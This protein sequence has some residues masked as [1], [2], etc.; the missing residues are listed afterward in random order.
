MKICL[1]GKNLTNFVLAKNLANKN[2]NVDI[3]CDKKKKIENSQRTLGIS[4]DNFDFLLNVNK[5]MKISA[6]PIKNIK[7]YNDKSHSKEF[8]EFNNK[9]KKN[10]FL[11]KYIDILNSFEKFC[12]KNKNIK[13]LNVNY[14]SEEK[15]YYLKK[16]YKL[17]IN[18]DK[19][20]NYNKK[21][22]NKKIEKNYN[23][24][25]YT[26]ILI[27]ERKVNYEAIQIFTKYGPLAFLPLSTNKTS[28]VFSILND[29]KLNRE[30]I[31]N[32]IK[33]YNFKY[34]IKK[35]YKIDSFELKSYNLRS[36]HNNNILAFGDLL[37]R[38]HPL[39]GQGF[40][41]TIRDLKV[42][43]DIIKNKFELGLPIDSSVNEEFEKSLKHK[44]FIF[45]NGIDLIHNLFNLDRKIKNNLL[46][47]SIQLIGKNY[48]VNKMF[49]KIADKGILF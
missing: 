5:K 14:Q 30:Q 42:L 27:H 28:I 36:Y 43:I 8:L 38:I 19:S 41:M 25:A 26:G 46:S 15:Q 12:K 20:N 34:K 4:K 35:I 37:H 18:S 22:L 39:A 33:K 23:S 29:F 45:T 9:N 21:Y 47:K 11:V 10:F 40:N 7:I 49:M 44:N 3:I 1:I 48:S 13:M 24:V 17:I 6:W 31:Y 16:K 2:I 32:L